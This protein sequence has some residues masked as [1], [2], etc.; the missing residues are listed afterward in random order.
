MY[1]KPGSDASLSS[2]SR[3]MFVGDAGAVS[4]TAVQSADTVNSGEV[5][6]RYKRNPLSRKLF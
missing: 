1:V 2:N 5:I 3:G 4:V 6:S